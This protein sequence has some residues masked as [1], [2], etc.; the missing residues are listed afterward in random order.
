[1]VNELGF[2]RGKGLR[3]RETP[4]TSLDRGDLFRAEFVAVV[5]A[6][7]LAGMRIV[8]ELNRCNQRGISSTDPIICHRSLLSDVHAWMNVHV[9]GLESH[10]KSGA[11]ERQI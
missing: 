1:M 3:N 7:Q 6:L 11:A 4:L 5:Y 2:G 9:H 8:T 10:T